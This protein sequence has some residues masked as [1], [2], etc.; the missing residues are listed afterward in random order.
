M[1]VGSGSHGEQTAKLLVELENAFVDNSRNGQAFDRVVVVGDVNS[2]MAATLAAVKLHIPVAHV[3]A[4][5]RSRDRKMP[6]EINRIVTDSLCDQLLVSEPDGVKNLKSEGHP[7]SNIH[8]VGNVMIDT[9]LHQVQKA[10]AYPTLENLGVRP[11]EYCMVT[12]HRPSNVDDPKILE[13][14]IDVLIDVSQRLTIVFPVHPRTSKRL[15]EFGL[16]PKL[17]AA[18]NIQLAEPMGLYGFSL[19]DFSVQSHRDGFRWVAGRVN[20]VVGS[21]S[22]HA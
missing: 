5:L 19:F 7:D 4:G 13:S 15:E 2:T 11:G 6:E 3:E 10:R 12:L 14:L 8:L 20:G 1:G 21:L 9:L 18:Q 22:H 16:Q 17:D